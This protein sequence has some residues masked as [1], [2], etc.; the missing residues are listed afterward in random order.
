MKEEGTLIIKSWPGIFSLLWLLA[1]DHS[2]L[3]AATK[4][5]NILVRKISTSSELAAASAELSQSSSWE[6]ISIYYDANEDLALQLNEVVAAGFDWEPE[7]EFKADIVSENIDLSLL[8]EEPLF[9]SQ[10]S[11][12]NPI[13]SESS[14]LG[15]GDIDLP[16]AF[17]HLAKKSLPKGRG[18]LFVVDSGL[19]INQPEL[20]G[21]YEGGFNAYDPSSDPTDENGHGTH[22]TSVVTAAENQYGMIGV[23][24][25]PEVKV[26]SV[27]F[28]DKDNKGNTSKAVEA[29][30]A[31]RQKFEDIKKD[32]PDARA[33]VNMSFGSPEYSNALKEA[34][35]NFSG[36]DIV[37][38]ASAGND[39]ND[40]DQ[41]AYWPCN[42]EVANLICVAASDSQD[43]RAGF[44]NYGKQSVDL[45][46]PGVGV[47]GAVIGKFQGQDYLATYQE[48]SGT[49][50]AA[51]HV[52]GAALL[53]WGANPELTATQV[54]SILLAS[55]DRLPDAENEVLS[56]GRLNTYRA[57][58]MAT[59]DDPSLANRNFLLED[60]G[61]GK[62]ASCALATNSSR[63]PVLT[64]FGL[65]L[66][67]MG[68][69]ILLRRPRGLSRLS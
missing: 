44:S 5:F 53:V 62:G 50:Q 10:W 1:I 24:P 7:V 56:G 32:N 59:G 18:Y 4:E 12:Y 25:D 8:E 37:L 11:L 28:L 47:L 27:K 55:V 20:D 51:P 54:K 13:V 3:H 61:A 2:G 23:A 65:W 48:K 46:A 26:F 29:L 22:V 64:G 30:N 57:V 19:D 41:K 15:G 49:S 39:A 35:Q 63:H 38:V 33:V 40:N 34:L 69:F 36:N 58:L 43:Y 42:Y 9:S 17:S 14:N 60:P 6:A 31:A 67:L 45:L 21:K 68:M 52:A 16:R 66:A